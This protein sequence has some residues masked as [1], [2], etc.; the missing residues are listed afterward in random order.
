MDVA[1]PTLYR[2]RWTV[3]ERGSGARLG[4]VPALVSATPFLVV[5]TTLYHTAPAHA[6]RQEGKFVERPFAL[7][8]VN[9]KTGAEVWTQAVGETSFKGPF[10]P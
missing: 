3:Y 10:P 9:L 4:S 2:H 6:A 5:G 7:R 1:E 8:A